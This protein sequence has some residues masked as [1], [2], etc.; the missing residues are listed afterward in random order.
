VVC[1]PFQNNPNYAGAG[2][3]HGVV[4]RLGYIPTGSTA[5]STFNDF[6]NRGT[7]MEAKLFLSDLNVPT[8]RFDLGFFSQD[9]QLLVDQTGDKLY[10]NF[11]LEM[12]TRVQ[13]QDSDAEGDYQFAVLSDDGAIVEIDRGNGWEV[14]INNDGLTPTRLRGSMN[15]VPMVRGNGLPLRVKYYQGPRFHIALVLLWRP[16]PQAGG[17][18]PRFGQSGNTLWFNCDVSP[19]VPKDPYFE[20][21]NRG[22]KPV[23]ARNF[24]LPAHIASNPCTPPPPKYRVAQMCT[25]GNFIPKP[26]LKLGL[27]MDSSD[28]SASTIRNNFAAIGLA[29]IEYTDEEVVARRPQTDGVTV[30]AVSRKVTRAPVTQAYIDALR[31]YVAEGGSL[32][33][34]YDGAAL[35]FTEFVPGQA[36]MNNTNPSFRLFDGTVAGGGALLPVESSRAYVIDAGHPLMAG[37]PANFL[38]GVRQAFAITNYD[39]RWLSAHA[40]FISTGF[41][42]L[43]PAGTYPAVMSARCGPSR[44][45]LFTMN[46]FQVMNQAPVSTMIQNALNWTVGQ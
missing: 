29:P 36:I 28:G 4:G 7:W 38:N 30:L 25:D 11:A 37:M 46:H 19:S 2:R 43:V 40:Q 14:L 6:Y 16:Y 9:G 22:W 17:A 34:E 26:T 24:Q 3:D 39:D 13:L 33:G 12:E 45:V 31:A 10:E 23:N 8:R 27:S 18:E 15:R 21:L 1:D 35:A 20:L 5:A 41:G 42:N 44:V 32:I